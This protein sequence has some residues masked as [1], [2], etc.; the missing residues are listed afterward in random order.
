LIEE[1][2]PE[3]RDLFEE[4]GRWSSVYRQFRRWTLAGL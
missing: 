2:N 3:W 1:M 4:F